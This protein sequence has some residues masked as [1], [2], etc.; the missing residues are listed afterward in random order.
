[1]K[2]KETGEWTVNHNTHLSTFGFGKR[3]CAG[4]ELALKQL[5]L[6]L[7]MLIVNY[8]FDI[9]HA[10][11]NENMIFKIPKLF[12]RVSTRQLPVVIKRRVHNDI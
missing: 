4:K 6:V 8:T 3:N 1:M 7:S 11:D 9:P 12:A 5:Y 10:Y 2:N